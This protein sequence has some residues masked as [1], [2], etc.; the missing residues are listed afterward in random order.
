L[1]GKESV[2]ILDDKELTEQG[3]LPTLRA[4]N[5]YVAAQSAVSGKD[6]FDADFFKLSNR[7]AELM[8][9]QFR[10]LLMHS[11]RA[12]EDAGY[13][14]EAIAQTSVYI[15]AS[16]SLYQAALPHFAQPQKHRVLTDANQYVSWLLAQGGTIPTMI[17]YK[18]GLKGPSYFVHSNCSSSLVGLYSAVQSIACGDASYALV[19]AAT[20]FPATS[21]GYLHQEGLN[22]SG[23]GHC[24]VFDAAADGMVCGEGVA[25]LR[26]SQGN[27]RQ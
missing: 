11:W 14:P 4:S 1:E 9:P 13:T 23:N 18:L 12:I 25:V 5:N 20:V 27:R 15:S 22:F 24:K 16:N 8:D 21:Q 3:V 7:D 6:L 10:L 19:G 26:D 2:V 17:S